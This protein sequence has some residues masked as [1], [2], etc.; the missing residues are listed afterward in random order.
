[1]SKKNKKGRGRNNW[2]PPIMP[3]AT[4]EAKPSLNPANPIGKFD[5]MLSF[6]QYR[7]RLVREVPS[8]YLCWIVAESKLSVP[9]REHIL[10]V[11]AAR[12]HELDGSNVMPFG[13]YCGFTFVEIPLAYLQWLLD[14]SDSDILTEKHRENIRRILREANYVPEH[15]RGSTPE[16]PVTT[17][18][19][20]SSPPDDPIPF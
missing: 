15:A 6:G 3:V 9:L 16:E 17:E 11:I 14:E 7:G 18:T 8:P 2:K 1:M 13:K 10:Q 5:L 4:Q 19:Q 20:A 12:G